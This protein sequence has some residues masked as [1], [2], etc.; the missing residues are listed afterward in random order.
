MRRAAIISAACLLVAGC[1]GGHKATTTTTKT[2]AQKPPP[3]KLHVGVVGPLT[4]SA[5]GAQLDRGPLQRVAGDPLVLADASVVDVATIAAA[6]AAHP[7]THFA[8]VGASTKGSHKPNLVGLVI[9][10]EQAARLAGVVAGFVVREEGGTSERVAWVGPQENSL[11]A[12]FKRGVRETVPTATILH[13]WSKRI[14][15]R[16]KEAALGAIG[17]GATVLVSHNGLCADAVAAAAHEQNHVALTLTDFE[18]PSTPA[19]IVARDAVAGVYHGG[20]DL[21]FGAPSGAI[22]VRTLDR[23]VSAETALRARA[24]AQELASGLRPSG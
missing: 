16:C 18:L 2:V 1:G 7:S 3:S 22:G 6:A 4:F 11:F 17:R 5:P 20:E 10:E 8:I 14:P 23:R 19:A 9:R 12:A 13:S 21:V 15:A 24:A